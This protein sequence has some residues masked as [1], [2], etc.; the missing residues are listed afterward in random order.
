MEDIGGATTGDHEGR[1]RSIEAS[2]AW[3][4][5]RWRTTSDH[6]GRWRRTSLGGLAAARCWR[7][8]GQLW[9][10][11]GEPRTGFGGLAAAR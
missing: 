9:L 10:R 6:G 1:W 11:G 5:L 2:R 4:A 7:R 3:A 8:R